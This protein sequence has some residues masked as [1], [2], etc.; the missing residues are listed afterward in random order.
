MADSL[1]GQIVASLVISREPIGQQFRHALH[2]HLWNEYGAVPAHFLL[3]SSD[4]L[5]ILN[6]DNFE[7][8]VSTKVMNMIL[9]G[10]EA[11]KDKQVFIRRWITAGVLSRIEKDRPVLV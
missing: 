9:L 2:Q 11:A 3:Q 10:Y 8:Q 6:L 4:Q 1:C 7:A 5:P